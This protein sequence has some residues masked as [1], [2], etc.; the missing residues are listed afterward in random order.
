MIVDGAF[1]PLLR[2]LLLLDD[3]VK[4]FLILFLP[5]VTF[6]PLPFVVDGAVVVVI[7]VV[8]VVA[9]FIIFWSGFRDP[10][11]KREV[12]LILVNHPVCICFCFV[13]FAEPSEFGHLGV[14]PDLLL[15]RLCLL[16]RICQCQCN[17]ANF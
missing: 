17:K 1:S 6:L 8:V 9:L 11:L 16:Y 7:I 13:Q 2:L 12:D 4:L 3:L 15:L 14:D 10:I 5:L